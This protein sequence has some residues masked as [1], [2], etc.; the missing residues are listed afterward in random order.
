MVTRIGTAAQNQILVSR[1]VDQ[2]HT[3]QQEQTTLATGL[4]SQDYAGVASDSY[5]LLNVENQK[6]RLTR[7]LSDNSL[8][9]TSLSAQNTAVQGITDTATTMRSLLVGFAGRDLSAKTPQDITDIQDLQTK[10]FSALSQVQYFLNQQIDGKYI[11]GG[12]TSDQPP[13]SLPYNNLDDFQNTY[14]G[15][16]TVF[17][18]SRVANL[19]NLNFDNKTVAYSSPQIPP[20]GPTATTYSQIQGNAGDFV[21][22]TIDQTATGNLVFSNVNGAGKISAAT[23]GAFKSLQV[24][25]T[26]LINNSAVAQGA[27]TGTDNNG[28]YTITAVSSDG[29]TIT[30]DQPVNAGTENAS[31][32]NVQINLGIPNGTALAM[33]GSTAGNDGAYTVKWPSNADLTAAGYNLNSGT[34]DIVSGE[35]IFSSKPIPVPSSSPE[36]VSL[37]SMAFLHGVSLPTEQK[38]SDTQT[39]KMDVTG[40]DPAF[41]KTIRAL[42]E[43]AQGDLLNNPDRIQQALSTL[44]DAIQHSSL[45]P[46]EAPSDLTAVA[47]RIANNVQ[48][49]TTAKDTQTDFQAFLA[50]RQ[51]DLI[52]AD[53]TQAAVQ[54]QTD[55]QALQVS[56]ASLAKITQLSLLNY[57]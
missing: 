17:P 52:Q 7:Y 30:L 4:K 12:A 54:L 5:D 13:V 29:N 49:L 19:V 48:I 36:T 39:I 32:D 18:S 47:D 15:I 11:F 1:M 27:P 51:N 25:Q 43:I 21:T 50:G 23:P 14:D 3:V 38:V 53:S 22:Q 26:I 41:E 9:Q 33:T 56:Y 20:S 31:S 10:A 8:V 57:L 28:V 16:G 40:L 2:Q 44:N 37:D 46:T 34:P 55:S 6:A 42:G 45:E 35:M 24:G